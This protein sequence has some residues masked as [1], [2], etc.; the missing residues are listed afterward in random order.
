MTGLCVRLCAIIIAIS[1]LGTPGSIV[2]H[3]AGRGKVKSP[4]PVVPQAERLH[5][6]AK[7]LFQRGNFEGA[8]ARWSEAAGLFQAAGKT[9]DQMRALANL[10]A[11]Y[12]S[13]G[14]PELAL[15]RLEEAL[16]IAL[17]SGDRSG[18][19]IARNH[20]GN[21][22][23][24]TRQP[25][26]GEQNLTQSLALARD[27]GDQGATAQ[28]LNDLGNLLVVQEREAQA[29]QAY[30]ESS[31]LAR[32][33]GDM[34]LAARATVN[35]TSLAVR[36]ERYAEA[37]RSN[38][39]ALSSIRQLPA[40]HDKA[41]LLLAVTHVYRLL[42]EQDAKAPSEMLARAGEVANSALMVAE[43]IDDGR[44]ASL[45]LGYSG[46]LA[47]K[48]GRLTE[49]M[50]LTRRARFMA[51]Q[52]QAPHLLYQWEWQVGRLLKSQGKLDD[53]IA[54]YRR[55]I[56]TLRSLCDCANY[57]GGN[58]QASFRESSGS[59]Y[60][61]LA[62][63]LLVRADSLSEPRSIQS[64]LVQARDTVELLKSAEIEEYFQDACVTAGRAKVQEVE[65]VLNAAAAIYY[66][67]LPERTEILLSLPSGLQRFKVPVGAG[68]LNAKARRLRLH[69]TRASSPQYLSYAQ[70]LY[71]LLLRPLEETLRTHSIKTLIFVPDGALRTIPMAALHDG[72]QF[73]IEKFSLAVTP[74]LTLMDPRPLARGGDLV[75][76]GGV[77][78]S[79]QGFQALDHVPEELSYLTQNYAAKAVLNKEFTK[80]TVQRQIMDGGYSIVHIA[81][82]GEF[83]SN[84][85][86]TY[87]L[88]YDS[89]LSLNDLE[90]TI[91]PR[92]YQGKPVELLVLSACQTAAGDDRAA[93]GLAGVAIKS[94]ARSA[95]AALWSVSDEATAD[96]MEQF[97]AVLK[98]EPALSK[99]AA[100]QKAQVKLL[101]D[102][103][104]SHPAF[105][106]PYLLI[107]NWL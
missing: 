85:K 13:L 42:A 25:G 44:S 29:R 43:Q 81:S 26:L 2:C 24:F 34:A 51:Q 104:F 23:T 86:R 103:R 60:Y 68:A 97:Y 76:A 63:L 95:L 5:A 12:Q 82:H 16:K 38:E 64:H 61:E 84:P 106:S 28:I 50:Q 78:E 59:L 17:R 21:L 102:E 53:A 32:A 65:A 47:E 62:D 4:D 94:G 33:A 27:E 57:G 41:Q 69:L 100:L 11:A 90:N 105:W 70:D 92:Q 98:R 58:A 7:E 49:A 55:A 45:A 6:A 99:A 96:L 30:S 88:T 14:Q 48:Q 79:V 67:V 89:K 91:R 107:G 72:Q 40:S 37:A 18:Q 52:T 93:L 74:G 36:A 83:S 75:F 20:L 1:F 3:A 54:A 35:L 56:A 22:Y 10:G 73:L 101:R 66:I 87:I 8:I 19:M 15:A 71:N 46:E 9:Q 80:D 77:S 31:V 39:E